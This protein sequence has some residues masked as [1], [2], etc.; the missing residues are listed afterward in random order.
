[1]KKN[2]LL[3]FIIKKIHEEINWINVITIPNF[4]KVEKVNWYPYSL[5]INIRTKLSPI[6]DKFSP[7]TVP[8]DTAENSIRWF[9]KI[10]ILLTMGIKIFV[11]GALSILELSIPVIHKRSREVIIIFPPVM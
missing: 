11:I 8:T 7:N 6:I 10:D 9:P 3:I 2:W 1:M 4:I 5:T